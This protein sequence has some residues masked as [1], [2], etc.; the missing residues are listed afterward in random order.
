MHLR[1]VHMNT[2]EAKKLCEERAENKR[3]LVGCRECGYEWLVDYEYNEHFHVE[4]CVCCGSVDIYRKQ[5][6]PVR[7]AAG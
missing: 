6:R 4:M 2:N 5:S 1:E 7:L 3:H